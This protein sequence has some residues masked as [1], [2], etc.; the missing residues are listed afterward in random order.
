[1][2][3]G[4]YV[5]GTRDDEV[6]RL[7]LQHRVWRPRMLDAWRRAG[8]TVGQTALDIGAGPGFATLDL[9]EIVG[10]AGKVIA[11]ERSPHFLSVLRARADHHGL[12]N[13]E[14][15]ERDVSGEE[16]LGEAVADSSWCRWLL[17]FVEHPRRTIGHVARA[18]K[19]GGTA[20]FHEY[21]DYGAWKMMPPDPLVDRFR[22]LVMQSWR[23]SGGEPDVAAFLPSWLEA[24]GLEIVETRPL[25]EIVDRS[26]F[27]WQWPAAFM[28]T[29]ALRLAELGYVDSA[30]AAR[31]ARALDELP[32]GTRM[33]TP[34]VVE[35]VARKRRA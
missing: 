11:F 21:G 29:G 5:L 22:T 32:A 34:L 26:S 6:D 24:E 8:I 16:S 7:G 20:I 19:P 17:S 3:E 25:I 13:I 12:A 31:M 23:D 33:V 2:T 28:A 4:D 9:A 14:A 10:P 15:H 1:M 30:E 18:L 35:V 27:V